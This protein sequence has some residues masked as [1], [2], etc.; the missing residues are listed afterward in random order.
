MSERQLAAIMFTDIVG[1]TALMGE[2]E[3]RAFKLLKR[4]REIQKPIIQKFGGKWVKEMG[5]GILASFNNVS[6]AVNCANKI[7]VQAKREKDL[8]LRIGLNEGEV[9]FEGDDVFGDGVNIAA[10]IQSIAPPGCIYLSEAVFNNIENKKGLGATFVREEQLKNVK[11]PIKIYE[12]VTKVDRKPQVVVTEKSIAVLPFVNMSGDPE[13]EYFSDGISEEI[14]NTIVQLPGLKVSARTSSFSFKGKNEDMRVIGQKL[15]VN[16]LLEGSIRKSGNQ[17]RI[18][19]QLI[20]AS[21]GFHLWSK[22]YDRELTDVFVIQD[23]I[24][25]EIADQLKITFK[26]P[27][28]TPKT[29]VQ[30]QDIDAYQL[31][32]KG[33]SFYYQRGSAL[34][35]GLKCFKA[36]LEIDSNYALALSGLADTYIMLGFWGLISPQ[37]SWSKAIPASKKASEYG[38][39]LSETHHTRAFIALMYERDYEAAEKEYK[40]AL[41]INPTNSQARIW[42]GLFYLL[43]IRND[44]TGGLEQ[45]KLAIENDPLSDYLHSCYAVAL[46][47]SD[48]FKQ[49]ITAARKLEP[50][51]T[52]SHGTLG[53]CLLSLG[54]VDDA[55]D[56]I[57]IFCKMSNRTQFSLIMLFLAYTKKGQQQQAAEI[58]KEMENFPDKSIQPTLHAI[59]AAILN[60]K[61]RALELIRYSIKIHDPNFPIMLSMFKESKALTHL[62][63]FKEIIKQAGIPQNEVW[64]KT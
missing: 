60:E 4:N 64:F 19:I 27:E 58:Y 11:N 53:L 33:R 3:I 24:A 17:V 15:G 49:A 56:E 41:E 54:K 28:E 32:F 25:L 26:G 9:V 5:D 47:Y 35:E 48:R 50:D 40:R 29:R 2:D 6:D 42:Y 14:I 51:S 23:E 46:I 63:E 8:R 44:V 37:E 57:E 16:N 45:H 36:A 21:T 20:E 12:L 55:L 18:T 7:Q 22:K 13:Q 31:Y 52:L 1:Y 39:D 10:R 62:P 38:P 59:A 43:Y 61:E 34:L 30:T